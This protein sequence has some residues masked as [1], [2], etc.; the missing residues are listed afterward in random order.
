MSDKKKYSKLKGYFSAQKEVLC[1]YLFGSQAK[2]KQNNYSDVDIAVLFEPNLTQEERTEKRLSLTDDL[3]SILN[4][5]VDVVALNDANSFLRFQVIKEGQRIYE[6]PERDEHNF[7][8]NTIV[9]Y[10]DFL[11]IRQRLETTMMNNIKRA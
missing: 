7:E 5:D 2:G 11:P 6:R 10:F 8:A 3:S 1:V 4:K 9:E